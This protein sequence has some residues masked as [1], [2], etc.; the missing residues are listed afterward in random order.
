MKKML[1]ILGLTAMMVIAA[2]PALA[3]VWGPQSTYYKGEKRATGKGDFT[4]DRNTYALNTITVVDDAP[5]DGNN[6]YGITRYYFF[7]NR[8]DAGP[9][10]DD[11][12]YDTWNRDPRPDQTAEFHGGNSLGQKFEH[13]K[14]LHPLASKARVETFACVQMG[15]PV[16][17][18]CAPASYPSFEY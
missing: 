18:G 2:Q 7:Y 14:E 5:G 17:D 3:A 13:R 10:T 6:V 15:W 4:N 9:R 11:D 12:C 8:C 1:T 16:P